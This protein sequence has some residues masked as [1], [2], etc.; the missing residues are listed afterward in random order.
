MKEIN[1]GNKTAIVTGGRRGIGKSIAV[2]LA[3]A[4]ADIAIWDIVDD[5]GQMAATMEEIRAM[6]RQCAG[7]RVNVAKRAEVEAAVQ[8]A[9]D[10]FGRIDILVS[11]AGVWTPGQSLAGC[12]EETWDRTI[13]T[14]LKGTF[15]CCTAAAEVMMKQKQGNI[16]TLSSQVGINP[17]TSVGAYSIS[18][19]GI[20]MLTRQLAIEL[21]PH[22]I[23]V[24]SIAP[25]MTRTEFTRGL[26][27]DEEMM[28]QA[29]AAVPL[30]RMGKPEEIAGPALF[31][32]SDDSSYMTGTVLEVDGG[33]RVPS[34]EIVKTDFGP[35]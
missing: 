20:I 7:F 2:A 10:S 18:K 11:C 22:N 26:W 33:W 15:F 14:N 24:N 5:D 1:L 35:G 27:S 21:A 12:T 23:R 19:A 16:I 13:N 3:Q 34:N 31:L 25:G 32:A 28:K 30:G 8:S 29:T 9:V 17:G 4:G 6:G